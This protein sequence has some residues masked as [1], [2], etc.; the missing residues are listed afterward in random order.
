LVSNALVLQRQVSVQARPD[1][2]D[3]DED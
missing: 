3:G 2:E 1:D